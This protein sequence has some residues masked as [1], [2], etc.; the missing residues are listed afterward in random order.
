MI[1]PS[2]SIPLLTVALVLRGSL[3]VFALAGEV[4]AFTAEF[5]FPAAGKPGVLLLIY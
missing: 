4:F 2:P 3:A 1:P 5:Q